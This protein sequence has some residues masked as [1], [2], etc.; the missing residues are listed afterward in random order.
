MK[1]DFK[2]LSSKTASMQKVAKGGARQKRVVKMRAIEQG[3]SVPTNREFKRDIKPSLPKAE[4]AAGALPTP[5]G[6]DTRLNI[7]MQPGGAATTYSSTPQTRAVKD[8]DRGLLELAA[9]PRVRAKNPEVTSALKTGTPATQ[10]LPPAQL[11][12]RMDIIKDRLR[13]GL[14]SSMQLG[15]AAW[16]H[17][18]NKIVSPIA[19]T[20]GALQADKMLGEYSPVDW[21][22]KKLEGLFGGGGA[23][24]TAP[25][26]KAAEAPA[27]MTGMVKEAV[28]ARSRRLA[29]LMNPGINPQASATKAKQIS[30]VR[31]NPN[32]GP[33]RQ[34]KPN[35]AEQLQIGDTHN[36]QRASG[37][38]SRGSLQGMLGK[39]P[40]VQ[41]VSERQ[42]QARRLLRERRLAQEARQRAMAETGLVARP[43]A[44]MPPQSLPRDRSLIPSPQLPIEIPESPS[45]LSSGG[46]LSGKGSPSIGNSPVAGNVGSPIAA[47]PVAA[48]VTK[49]TPT[50]ATTTPAP[51]PTPTASPATPAAS[52]TASP[53]PVPATLVTPPPSKP[54][55]PT[56]TPTPATGGA[57]GGAGGS[58]GASAGAGAPS[59]G[60]QGAGGQGAAAGAG[61]AT[62]VATGAA[63]SPAGGGAGGGA[64]ATP[65]AGGG[66]PAPQ[67]AAGGMSGTKGMLL[68]AGLAGGVSMIPSAI[69][70]ASDG[71]NYLNDNY[72]PYSNV[73]QARQLDH[74]RQ[75]LR[76]RGELASPAAPAANP[77]NPNN[78]FG[79]GSLP[80]Y[81][82]PN[83]DGDYDDAN[84]D[85]ADALTRR[86]ERVRALKARY[87]GVNQGESDRRPAL[88]N[89]N[90]Y[91]S[92]PPRMSPTPPPAPAQNT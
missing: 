12:S 61:A 54:A 77:N 50:S 19:G 24:P 1:I 39:A 9:R 25:A 78:P 59:P 65:G 90:Q 40:A 47:S 63:T 13:K 23:A 5:Q 80:S 30:Q 92:T 31:G 74:W 62:G 17:P 76:N 22:A 15:Q 82:M 71:I 42:L 56:P 51:S 53:S 81:F 7:K 29:K 43:N 66:G 26:V 37:A 64:A 21:A 28:G 55:T 70:G 45:W 84:L 41:Q 83:P 52:P 34:G 3:K 89:M 35:T 46:N 67:P 79:H 49:P 73:Y 87:L 2:K 75:I 14:L 69:Q 60:G 48:P 72:N 16:K 11:A 38:T 8:V 18:M 88:R 36:R 32:Y 27:F 91:F 68:G 57:G 4:V 85:K 33:Q 6:A 58:S 86:E 10:F 44:G 20:F